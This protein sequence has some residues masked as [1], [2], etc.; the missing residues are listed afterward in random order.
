MITT[1]KNKKFLPLLLSHICGTLNDNIVKNIFVFLTAY[2]LTKGSVYWIA[3]AFV[4]YGLAYLTT[5]AFA[6]LFADKMSK[7][8]MIQRL[9]LLEVGIMGFTLFSLFW[10]SRILMLISLTLFGFCMSAIRIAKYAV[11]PEI[12]SEKSLLSANALIKGFT[13]ISVL[14]SSFLLYLLHGLNFETVLEIMGGLLIVSAFAG[15]I[16]ALKI[17]QT[18]VQDKA[19][20]ISKNPLPFLK[21]M[22]QTVEQTPQIKFYLGSIA[23]YWLFGGVIGFFVSGFFKNI[24]DAKPSVVVFAMMIFSAGYVIGSF[25]CPKISEKKNLKALIPLCSVGISVF[26]FD[27]LWAAAHIEATPIA[28]NVKEFLLAGFNA[29]RFLFDVLVMGVCAAVFIIPFYP[30]LQK[31]TPTKLMGRMFAYTALICGLAVL[32][33]ILI[34]LSLMILQIPLMLIFVALSIMNLFF[35]VY[36]CQLLS[37]ETRRKIFKKLLSLLFDV[38]ITGLEN[39]KKAGKR[40]LIIPNHTS[41]IDALFISTFIDQPITFCLTNEVAGKWWVRFFGNLMNIKALD[42]NSAFAVKTMVEELK[43][44]KLCMIFTDAHMPGGNTKMKVYEGPAL[45]A[46]KADAKVLPIQIKG[47]TYSAYSRLKGKSY[48]NLF[49][50]VTIEIKEA[51]SLKPQEGK[52]FRDARTYSS[53]KLYQALSL[54]RVEETD[55]DKT[56]FDAIIDSMGRVGRNKPIMEDTE[57]KPVK[58]KHVFMKAFVLGNLINKKLPD[59]DILGVMLPTSNACVLTVLGLHA[60]GKVPAMINFTSGP[61]QVISTCKTA[62]IKKVLTA[63]KVILLA[64]LEGLIEAITKE[65]IEVV[66]LEDLRKLLTFKDKVDAVKAM[67]MPRRMYKKNAGHV[68]STDTA[69]ILFTSGSEGMPKGVLLTHRNI[70]SNVFQLPALYDVWPRDVILNC[71]PMF[72]SFGLTAGVFLPLLVGFK[73]VLYPTPLHYRVIPELCSAVQAT[74]LFATDTFLAGYAKCANPYDFNSLRIVVGGAEKVK[75]ETRQVWNEKFGIRL[76][77]GYGATECSPVVALNSFLFNKYGSVGRLLPGMS[78]KLREV[79]G[80]K[81]GQELIVRG[82][83]I[84]QGYMKPDKPETLQP[85]KDGWYDTGDIVSIDEDGFIFIKG[86]SKRFAK[87]GGEMVSLL[88]VEMVIS[89]N[90][91]GFVSGAVSV[92]DAKKGEQIVLITTCKDIT[93]EKLVEAFKKAG[94]TELAIPKKVIFTDTPPLLGTGKFD[95]VTAKDVALKEVSK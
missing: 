20:V 26:M 14:A 28:Y 77:E 86:R 25:V 10:E 54:M 85:P 70:I 24:M 74:I 9:K 19:V 80:I 78:Y 4:L 59:D 91:P 35:A 13:F 5:S 88:S 95:Y 87:I 15:Y 23:W 48:L 64:K 93:S 62:G 82:P 18:P 49:P 94:L 65:G 22:T 8:K 50:K 39:I 68:K 42:P 40:V 67:L 71:L 38:E 3:V 6:G 83:N 81:E 51:I 45:M 31:A 32:G 1:L 11:I 60:Y 63:K 52:T 30:L 37:F 66:Y 84:M 58:F 56:V 36:T 41:Y 69:V 21:E 47:L 55:F 16:F 61:K 43:S 7:S 33:A 12:V 76:F 57:R 53:D 73:T 79:P 90:W 34:V 72:H 92:P 29:Y 75:D 17:P 27:A 46:Q 44:E 89:E 2:Q